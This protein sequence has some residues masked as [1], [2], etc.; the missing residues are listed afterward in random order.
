LICKVIGRK[1]VIL[2]RI[3]LLSLIFGIAFLGACSQNDNKMNDMDQSSM[4]HEMDDDMME[5]HMDHEDEVSL[6]DSTGKNELKIPKELERDEKSK[7]IVYTVKA[8]KGETEIFDGIKTDT[9][10]YNGAR[11]EERRVGKDRRSRKQT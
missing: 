9:I 8:Q 1:V 6:N 11:S 4:E 7:E 10:G 2:K 3:L 5:E